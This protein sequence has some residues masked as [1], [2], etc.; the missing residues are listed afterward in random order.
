MN[1]ILA[2]ITVVNIMLFIGCGNGVAVS[3]NINVPQEV[4]MYEDSLG[5]IVEV[6]AEINKIAVTGDIAQMMIFALAPDTMVGTAGGWSESVKN[7][8]PTKY[9]DLPNLGKLYGTKG[10]ISL[11]S[12]LQTQPD[13]IIDIG[14]A[15]SGIEEDLNDLQE[16]LNIPVVH[17]SVKLNSY[18]EAFRELGVL[19][20]D[21]DNA[22]KYASFCE[23][24]YLQTTEIMSEV[25]ENKKDV[26]YLQGDTG[27]FILPQNSYHSELLDLM[28]NNLASVDTQNSSGMGVEVDFEQILVWNPEVI[29]F[30]NNAIFNDIS[31]DEKWNSLNA[32]ANNNFYETPLEPYNWTGTPP[33][34]QQ[35]L[36]MMW[37]TELLYND[38]ITYDFENNVKKYFEMFYH[39]ELSQ[40]NYELL[41]ENSISK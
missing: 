15:K 24:I 14:E 1:K 19:L 40:T 33:S 13:I 20:N 26:I 29:I 25:G 31:N 7:C 38:Y 16:K 9:H 10:D 2:M 21:T 17:I 18:G 37:Y 23:E 28:T 4:V 3:E 6:P 41:I 11:E 36:G 39:K 34:V 12:I 30:G 22:E 32:V 5:R 27:T 35:Y 8:I